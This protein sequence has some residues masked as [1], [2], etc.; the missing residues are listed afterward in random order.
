MLIEGMCVCV[1]VN[2][3]I[4]VCFDYFFLFCINYLFNS[5]TY[6]QNNLSKTKKGGKK[7]T[8]STTAF[9]SAIWDIS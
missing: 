9:I 6:T 7:E 8:L 5:K 4:H 3:H 1:C 2:T